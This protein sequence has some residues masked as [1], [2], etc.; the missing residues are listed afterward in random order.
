MR[1]TSMSLEIRSMEIDQA[2]VHYCADGPESGPVVLL[3]HGASFSSKTWE[4]LGTLELLAKAGFRAY[5]VDLPGC[6]QSL[7]S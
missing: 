1:E 6:R 7:A 3:L 4:E 5:A 2:R